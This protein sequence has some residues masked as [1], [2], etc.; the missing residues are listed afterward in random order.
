MYIYFNLN[1]C[2]Y[3]YLYSNTLKLTCVC[4]VCKYFVYNLAK[5]LHKTSR[6]WKILKK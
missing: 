2:V 1:R 6:E 5:M 4:V 3:T